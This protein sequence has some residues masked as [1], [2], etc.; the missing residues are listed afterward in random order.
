MLLKKS[1]WAVALTVFLVGGITFDQS[2][3]TLYR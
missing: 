2:F 1:L 3:A